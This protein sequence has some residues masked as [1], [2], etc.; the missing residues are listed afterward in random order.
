MGGRGSSAA[1]LLA[2][3]ALRDARARENAAARTLARGNAKLSAVLL[4]EAKR[5]GQSEIDWVEYFR[6]AGIN[7]P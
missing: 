2:C 6:G 1:A 5:R 7:Y 3:L 4:D